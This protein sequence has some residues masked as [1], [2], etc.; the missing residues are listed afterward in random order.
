[1]R[2][3]WEKAD[4]DDTEAIAVFRKREKDKMR[5]RK[6]FKYE[7]SSYYKMFD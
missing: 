4:L 3:F 1:M 7:V 6:K 5:L 2:M